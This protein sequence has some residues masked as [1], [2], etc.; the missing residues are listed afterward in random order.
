MIKKILLLI[1]NNNKKKI[2]CVFLFSFFIVL[3]EVLSLSSIPVFFNAVVQPDN[4]QNF[5]KNYINIIQ[6]DK[7]SNKEIIL[8]TSI[9]LVIIFILKNIIIALFIIF[10]TSVARDIRID[11]TKKLYK[12][13]LRLPINFHIKNNPSYLIRNITIEAQTACKLIELYVIIF[14]ELTIVLFIF[15]SIAFLNFKVFIL[16]I[17]LFVLLGL[18]FYL[19]FKAK[20]ARRGELVLQ[21][22]GEKLKILNSTLQSIKSIKISL[23]ESFAYKIFN[24]HYEQEERH[25]RWSSVISKFPRLFFE[26]IAIVLISFISIL[27]ASHENSKVDFLSFITFF[28]VCIVRIIPAISS[29][30]GSMTTI[31]YKYSGAIL[32]ANHI[33]E[34]DLKPQSEKNIIRSK[35]NLISTIQTITLKNIS[36]SYGKKLIFDKFNFTFEKSKIYGIVGK[37]GTG[38]S[39]LLDLMTSLTKPKSGQIVVNEK[40]DL[41]QVK[42][43][44]RSRTG[45]VPQ[46]IHLFDDTLKNNITLAEHDNDAS[47]DVILNQ[48]ITNFDLFEDTSNPL[49]NLEMNVANDGSNLSGGQ[50]QRIGLIRALYKNPDI[51]ILDEFTSS[52]DDKSEAKILKHIC[53]FKLNRIIIIISHRSE[54]LKICDEIINLD[55]LCK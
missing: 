1:N 20:A 11:N 18:L 38:K 34:F 8:Y 51:I 50:A 22:K 26:I 55:N 53:S 28:S 23:A 54:P 29:I 13:Y 52:L 5:F 45:Y 12:H 31:K 14:R 47:L 19:F 17:S 40:Y 4:F 32:V 30:L 41:E 27:Y 2:L 37:S 39:T 21:H 42:L 24:K 49:N 9:I 25:R 46:K 6:I 15:F 44:V 36:F 43:D 35:E 3:L 10:E 48:Y 33:S 7:Y 16:N